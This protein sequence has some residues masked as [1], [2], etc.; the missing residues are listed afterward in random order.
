MT[1]RLGLLAAFAFS[2]LFWWWLFTLL[3]SGGSDWRDRP[4]TRFQGDATAGVVFTTEARV[5]RMCPQVRNAVGCTVGGTIYVP[6]PCRWGDGYATL[7][8]HEMA[9]VSGWSAAHER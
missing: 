4:P 2:G 6:N 9:H 7:M 3:P 5:Q 1:R 8:C